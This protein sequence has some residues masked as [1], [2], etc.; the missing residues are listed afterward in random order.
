MKV[1]GSCLMFGDPFLIR[2]FPNFLKRFDNLRKVLLTDISDGI[3]CLFVFWQPYFSLSSQSGYQPLSWSFQFSFWLWK[4]GF[5]LVQIIKLL[6][7]FQNLI[8]IQ[9]DTLITIL[10]IFMFPNIVLTTVSHVH[11]LKQILLLTCELFLPELLLSGSTM[12]NRR[13][14]NNY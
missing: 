4:C 7:D 10:D 9:S 8:H 13:W 11:R 2:H 12:I 6:L 14:C 3:P 1:A 5:H